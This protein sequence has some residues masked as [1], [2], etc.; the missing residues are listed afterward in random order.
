MVGKR[1]HAAPEQ[2]KLAPVQCRLRYMM[3]GG[4]MIYQSDERLMS[5]VHRD[6]CFVD[7]VEALGCP[8][9]PELVARA[10]TDLFRT[11]IPIVG[12]GRAQGYSLWDILPW[13]RH[14]LDWGPMLP[15]SIFFELFTCLI[16]A[17][18]EW[19]ENPTPYLSN[20]GHD[21][22]PQEIDI[23]RYSV[24]DC[25]GDVESSGGDFVSWILLDAAIIS[26]AG[27][28]YYQDE[29]KE[30]DV[31]MEEVEHAKAEDGDEFI[32]YT[33]RVIE[34]DVPAVKRMRTEK[35]EEA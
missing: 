19:L 35:K 12:E 22:L 8:L 20:T 34:E 26:D 1:K 18:Q 5:N 2:P 21:W 16:E 30:E 23:F 9:S 25:P 11:A 7:A 4:G 13:L 27:R 14:E 29:N 31:E 17:R 15:K 10:L 33:D 24:G 3:P 6:K 28:A 32:S